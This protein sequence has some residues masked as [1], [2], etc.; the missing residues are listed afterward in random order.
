MRPVTVIGEDAPDAVTA[1]P[2]AGIAVTMYAD[3]LSPPVFTGAAK[4]TVAWESPPK[5][6]TP[7]GAP[8]TVGVIV[9]V[10]AED[11]S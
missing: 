6:V 10:P 3:R 4:L 8:G 5:A 9:R 2:E 11:P 1:L 7:V